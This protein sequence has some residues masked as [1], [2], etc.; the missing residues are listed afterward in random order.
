MF[1]SQTLNGYNSDGSITKVKIMI[2]KTINCG[3]LTEFALYYSILTQLS[4]TCK[5]KQSGIL[6]TKNID[7]SI[8]LLFRNCELIPDLNSKTTQQCI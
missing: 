5:S 8:D 7:N 3:A 6:A 1:A 2:R 4:H